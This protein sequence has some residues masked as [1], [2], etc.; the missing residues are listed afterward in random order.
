MPTTAEKLNN[1]CF[2]IAPLG[3]PGTP[4][5]KRSDQILKHI[6]APASRECGFG[7]PLRADG[8][9]EAGIIT[10]QVIQHLIDDAVVIA[11][12]TDHNP[13]V[14]YELAVR[15]AF[16]KPVIQLIQFDQKIPFDVAGLR[17]VKFDHTDLD[18]AAAAMAELIQHLNA[19]KNQ[20]PSD[21]ESPV[22][23]AV[24][25]ETLR[26][27]SVKDREMAKVLD[28]LA[29]LMGAVSSLGAHVQHLDRGLWVSNADSSVPMNSSQV[30]RDLA[31]G[32]ITIAGRPLNANVT[33][34]AL[35]TDSATKIE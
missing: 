34:R 33:E 26:S 24:D 10:T 12:L 17:T 32:V 19:I 9:A 7:E 35:A 30:A 25:R 18:S 16:R 22:T 3:D 20:K 5:R 1:N 23:V 29:E 8:I 28:N 27:G 15:H 21:V 6:I 2:V 13:N 31:R 4:T 11:D 14:F